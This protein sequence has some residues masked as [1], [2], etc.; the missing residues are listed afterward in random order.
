MVALQEWPEK[1]KGKR[2]KR[3]KVE[4]EKTRRHRKEDDRVVGE[5]IY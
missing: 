4:K 2:R 1:R 3:K 5:R